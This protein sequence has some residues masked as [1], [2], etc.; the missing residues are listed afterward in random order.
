M[1]LSKLEDVY[2]NEDG[3]NWCSSETGSRE[4]SWDELKVRQNV[5]RQKVLESNWIGCSSD[6]RKTCMVIRWRV[7]WRHEKT[8]QTPQVEHSFNKRSFI[9][10]QS[11]RMNGRMTHMCTLCTHVHVQIESSHYQNVTSFFWIEWCTCK[12][13]SNSIQW[14]ITRG[15]YLRNA[16]R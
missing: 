11:V 15:F 5:L 9:E 8:E 2:V 3:I 10:S 16:V 7:Q 6:R 14:I 1:L 4:M 13:W 12:I